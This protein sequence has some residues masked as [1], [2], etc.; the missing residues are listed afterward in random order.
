[1]L[2]LSLALLFPCPAAEP[3]ESA[4]FARSVV[5]GGDTARLQQVLAKARRG[6][7]IT[8]GVIGGS[9]TAGAM[10]SQP[11]KCYGQLVA[12]WWRKTFPQAKI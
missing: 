3:G 12:A 4:A 8:V 11:E 7:A 10:A 6:E 5:S 9:I 1:V 2:V